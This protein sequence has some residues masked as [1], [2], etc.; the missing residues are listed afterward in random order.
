MK[1][2]KT[3]FYFKLIIRALLHNIQVKAK[4]LKFLWHTIKL[5]MSGLTQAL[6]HYFDTKNSL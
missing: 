5:E 1:I 6:M 2:I 4:S 3:Y